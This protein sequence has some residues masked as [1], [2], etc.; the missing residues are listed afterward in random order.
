MNEPKQMLLEKLHFTSGK[1]LTNAVMMLFSKNP[2]KW[3][4]GAYVKVGYF[5][6]DADLIYQDE[7]RGSL[8]EIV[9]RIIDLVYFKYMRAKITYVGMQRR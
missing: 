6:T 7:I 8:I 4:L 1:Y 3:Q 2:E 9:D 5:E